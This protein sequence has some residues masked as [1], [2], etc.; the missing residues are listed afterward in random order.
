M[1]DVLCII[2]LVAFG[3]MILIAIIC[4]ILDGYGTAAV[5]IGAISLLSG[6]LPVIDKTNPTA[7]D[8]Y[9]GKTTL[10]IT[11]KGGVPVDTVVV[12]KERN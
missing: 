12:F 6:I 11:Y 10:E 5:T 7:I 3:L 9:R 2:L 4:N 8:V 1:L